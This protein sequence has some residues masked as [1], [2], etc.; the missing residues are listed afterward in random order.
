MEK[1]LRWSASAR[2]TPPN[3]P[4]VRDTIRKRAN[5]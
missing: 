1:T 5:R 2:F 4:S 3:P